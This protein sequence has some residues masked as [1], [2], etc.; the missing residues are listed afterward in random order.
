MI[1]KEKANAVWALHQEGVRTSEIAQKLS[2]DRKTVKKI[3]DNKGV[4]AQKERK[5]KLIL[6]DELIIRTFKKC[7][8]WGQRTHEELEKSGVKIAYS[9]LMRKIREMGLKGKEETFSTP[10]PDLPGVESQH[11]LSPYTVRVGDHRLKLQASLLHY[12]YS[13][14]NYLKFYPSFNRFNMKN[15]F[16]EALQY[17]EYVPSQC[18][19]D[20]TSLVIDRG[21]GKNAVF[22]KEM[23]DF[24]KS[25]GFKWYAHSI[26]H[27]DR[28]AGVERGFYTITQNFFP[29]REFSSLE[30][31]NLQARQW[32]ES[33]SKKMN[34]NKIIPIDRF[35]YEKDF[36]IKVIPNTSEPYRQHT[37][38]VDQEGY[39]LFGTN[40][41]WAGVKKNSE[42]T[43]L[44]YS[45]RIVIYQNRKIVQEHKLPTFGTR[46]KK[47]V[48]D[49]VMIPYRPKKTTVPPHDEE[50]ELRSSSALVKN[51]LDFALKSFGPQNR[52]QF[53]REVYHL[54]K[55]LTPSLFENTIERAFKYRI[56]SKATLEKIAVYIMNKDD[57]VMPELEVEFALGDSSNY[58]DGQYGHDPDLTTYDKKWRGGHEQEN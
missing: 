48:P 54:Y 52:Y 19:I 16:Y 31:L 24:A 27:S 28:K 18:V 35:E 53:I 56:R 45:D 3:I 58:I 10:V 43:V 4:I 13:K 50:K 33:R 17:F 32:C 29:G 21:S 37:R 9:T 5:D 22:N 40:L 55:N 25:F 36:M 39:V 34:K 14:M 30:D 41:F 44:E 6:D 47:I 57:F 20:N 51:Y 46:T 23:V 15:F 26:R 38:S 2:I 1:N 42:V 7:D 49:G 8:E 11:D 12:R